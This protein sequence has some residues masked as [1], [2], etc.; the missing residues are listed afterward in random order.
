MTPCSR[1]GSSSGRALPALA[2][3]LLL[4]GL[5]GPVAAQAPTHEITA[6]ALFDEALALMDQARYAEACPK[7]AE[8]QRL[9]PGGGTLLNLARCHEQEGKLA[10]AWTEF[11]NAAAMARADRRDD[12]LQYAQERAAALEPRL[13]KLTILVPGPSQVAG[14]EVTL[15]DSPLT[16][17]TW[18]V[19]LPVDLGSHTVRATARGFQPWEGQLSVTEE[20]GQSSLTVPVLAPSP[21]PATPAPGPRTPPA[22]PPATSGSAQQMAGYVV[23]AAGLVAGLVGVVFGGLAI[24]RNDESEELCPEATCPRN[25]DGEEAVSLNE[26]ARTDATLANAFVGGGLGLVAIGLVVLLTA[27]DEA[28]SATEAAVVVPSLGRDGGGL[29]VRFSW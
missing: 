28:A 9:D 18:G 29:S 19:A 14:L 25:E 7:L 3:A 11:K 24:S 6:Q 17:S 2:G 21:E 16:Q 22:E 5:A 15:D 26:E 1:T 8:S 4:C 10:T 23:G 12:R 20:A 27:P 13:S